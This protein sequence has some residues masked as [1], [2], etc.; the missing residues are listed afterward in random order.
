MKLNQFNK[1]NQIIIFWSISLYNFISI[2]L[3]IWENYKINSKILII[4]IKIL[5]YYKKNNTNTWI[6]Q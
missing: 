2:K 5:F 6:K 4:I 3:L 1:I